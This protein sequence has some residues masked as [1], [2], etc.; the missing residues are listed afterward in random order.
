MKERHWLG[1]W[2]LS[3]FSSIEAPTPLA[4]K[5]GST[6]TAVP[7]FLK[8]LQNYSAQ[9]FQKMNSF[10]VF[11]FRNFPYFSGTLFW[12]TGTLIL[13]NTSAWMVP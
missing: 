4:T 2:E 10:M 11:V 8:N 6:K 12:N 9:L 3:R 7:N 1:A 5:I 13:R